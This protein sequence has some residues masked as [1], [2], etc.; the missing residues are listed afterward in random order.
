MMG[1]RL[2][3]R[4]PA[5]ELLGTPLRTLHWIVRCSQP[6]G[7][8]RPL[9]PWIPTSPRTPW[10]S[11]WRGLR[12]SAF[13]MAPGAPRMGGRASTV[14]SHARLAYRADSKVLDR[15]QLPRPGGFAVATAYPCLSFRDAPRQ[16]VGT[17]A[18][19]TLERLGGSR[20]QV[21]ANGLRGSQH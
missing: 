15:D 6:N 7:R 12:Q 21:G 14:P 18:P 5:G 11:P 3:A 9:P 10:L 13:R 1:R 17:V 8:S 19:S 2:V 16:D 20:E 4:K